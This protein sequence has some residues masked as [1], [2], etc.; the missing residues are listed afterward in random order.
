MQTIEWQGKPIK[1][2]GIY[3]GMPIEFYHSD[4]ACIETSISSSG[5]RTIFNDSPAQYW[6]T[7]PY[8]KNR[9]EDKR[10]QAFNI[11][12]AAH[13]LLLG[14]TK[15]RT[16]YAIRP[17]QYK[18]WKTNEAKAWREVQEK[19]NLIALTADDLEDIKGMADA[20]F[21]DPVLRETKILNGDIER[22]VFQKDATTGIWLKGRPDTVPSTIMV[23]SDLKTT[24]DVD[25]NE[26]R[27]AVVK[28]RYD[29]QAALIRKLFREVLN[30]K[31]EGFALVFVTKK[32]PYLV[33]V[34]LLKEHDLDAAEE[35]NEV[36]LKLFAQCWERKE[37]LGP[38]M[39]QS[40]T[41]YVEFSEFERKRAVE[42]RDYLKAELERK[43]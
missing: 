23:P 25:I 10:N 2:P 38:N 1:M 9:A 41:R 21:R 19:K 7:S 4:K 16:K 14:E 31:I 22:S 3:H 8:N 36:A 20:L 24:T 43:R 33:Q 39:T 28:F 40:D 37:W 30:I 32:R 6:D 17:A 13:H 18:D 15:F 27:R 42:R 29:M 5:L 26:V 34:V 35:D 11:G 12:G